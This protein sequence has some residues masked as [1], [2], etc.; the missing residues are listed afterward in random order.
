MSV[1]IMIKKRE[2]ENDKDQIHYLIKFDVDGSEVFDKLRYVVLHPDDNGGRVRHSP[3]LFQCTF[4]TCRDLTVILNTC[5]QMVTDR[6][7]IYNTYMVRL[8]SSTLIM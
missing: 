1:M 7:F 8:F 3:V 6:V 2:R 4:T 5:F